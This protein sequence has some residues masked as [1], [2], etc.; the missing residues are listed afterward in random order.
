MLFFRFREKI[1][2]LRLFLIGFLGRASFGNTCILDLI[3][4]SR[5]MIAGITISRSAA[6]DY[7]R[8]CS[9]SLIRIL[10]SN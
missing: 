7:S 2:L 8:S 10:N 5:L 9:I 1:K 6:I 4:I 3:A